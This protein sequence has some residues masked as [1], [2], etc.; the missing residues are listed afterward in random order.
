[1]SGTKKRAGGSILIGL[2]L[3]CGAWGCDSS[4]KKSDVGLQRSGLVFEEGSNGLPTSGQWRQ[5]LSFHDLNG[6]GHV[7]IVA[8]PRRVA[9]EGERMPVVWY[10]N[11]QGEWTRSALEA[12]ANLYYDY[13]T[14][15]IADFTN[16]GVLDIGLAMHGLG[17]RVLKGEKDGRF[18]NSSEGL[19][20]DSE[21]PARAL[22]AA[23]I[24]RDG[25]S[26]IVALR[27][28]VDQNVL[29]PQAGLLWCA[30]HDG[31]WKCRGIGDKTITSGLMGDQ[32]VVGDVDNDG[33]LDLA[34]SSFNHRNNHIVW[35]GDGTGG[36]KPF[37]TGLTQGKHYNSVA[38]AD[39]NGDGR[40]DLVASVSSFGEEF[41]GVKAFISGPDGFSDMSEGMPSGEKAWGYFA[42]A[43]DLDG[44]GA[45][46]IISAPHGGGLKVYTLKGKQWHEV[47]TSGLPE[48]GLYRIYNMYC[49]D[50]NQDGRNDIVIVYS[51]ANDDSGAIR[52]FLNASEKK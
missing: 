43:G 41:K 31:M 19:P 52:V 27:E 7:D 26:D 44:D 50:I 13:G 6:D 14:V 5:G 15:S 16:D 24:D 2:L 17:L 21:F 23:D 48:K 22:I 45:A 35:L 9:P 39:V 30:F 36:F 46:E 42:G 51:D 32:L 37:N 25:V 40:D 10:G 4:G 20:S 29:G 33:N 3:V 12:P 11:G 47:K 38:L 28:Y 49:M 18:V 1:M 34:V 8:T